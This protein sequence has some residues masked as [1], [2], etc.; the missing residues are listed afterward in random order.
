MINIMGHTKLE[1]NF[2]KVQKVDI[3]EETRVIKK[4]DT[5]SGESSSSIVKNSENF[6]MLYDMIFNE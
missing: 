5:K 4:N 3:H 1:F 6:G 2:G